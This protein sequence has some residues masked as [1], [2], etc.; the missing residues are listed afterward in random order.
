MTTAPFEPAPEV[1]PGE[2]P[3]TLPPEETEPG[4]EPDQEES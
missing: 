3:G 1:A 2:D 4:P